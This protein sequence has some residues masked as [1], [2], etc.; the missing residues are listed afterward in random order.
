MEGESASSICA[1]YGLFEGNFIRTVLKTA[2]M[3]DELISLATYCQHIPLIN[4]LM[5]LRS[6]LVRDII[7]SDSLYLHL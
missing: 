6:Q 7:V 2:N 5:E 4:Q 1:A 3:V